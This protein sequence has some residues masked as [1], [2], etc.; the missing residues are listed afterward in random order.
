MA[1]AVWMNRHNTY[2]GQAIHV[3]QPGGAVISVNS[4]R[5]A[6]GQVE[7]TMQSRVTLLDETDIKIDLEP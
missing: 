2:P 3:T 7:I 1:L 4:E 6:N 5:G